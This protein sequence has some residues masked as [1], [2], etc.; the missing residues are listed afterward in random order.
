M[1]NLNT[2]VSVGL[3]VA[4]LMAVVVTTVTGCQAAPTKV[5][6]ESQVID[7]T[8]STG[9]PDVSGTP[10]QVLQEE[11][12]LLDARPAFISATSP[13]KQA[14]TID[15][16]DFTRRIAP[17]PNAMDGDLFFHARRLARMGIAPETRVLVLG[18]G[19][20]GDG[21]EGRLA[22][23]LRYLGLTRVD[24]QPADDFR[25]Q[26]Q[27]NQSPRLKEAPI[28]KPILDESLLETRSELIAKV[29]S[30]KRF[31]F[32]ELTAKDRDLKFPDSM[33]FGAA[34]RVKFSQS[35]F[36]KMATSNPSALR[37]LFSGAVPTAP[38]GSPD[39]TAESLAIVVID[40]FGEMAGYATMVL[41]GLGYPASCACS[42]SSEYLVEPKDL[43]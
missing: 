12:V 4:S 22:W 2:K 29:K 15:W 32:V 11:I 9:L 37:S 7:A 35:D 30:D 26:L 42:G 8:G 36:L 3:F 41:R 23:T 43:K 18:R 27:V 6:E 16:R 21:E 1:K 13:I 28:W 31:Y 10:G 38:D 34:Q 20:E 40:P 5:V 14:Q 17:R 39:P 19:A 24:F 25:P 33:Q